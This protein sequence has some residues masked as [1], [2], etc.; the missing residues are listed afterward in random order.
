M[1]A[2]WEEI[3][4]VAGQ[5]LTQ[6]ATGNASGN[7]LQN[8][9]KNTDASGEVRNLLRSRGVTETRRIARKAL[10]RRGLLV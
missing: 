2:N 9:V 7:A 3:L 8:V 6:F 4:R 1:R 10:R 5:T